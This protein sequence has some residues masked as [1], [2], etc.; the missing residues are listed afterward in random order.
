MRERVG[1]RDG[2]EESAGFSENFKQS[3]PLINGG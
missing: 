1:L 3:S 2:I